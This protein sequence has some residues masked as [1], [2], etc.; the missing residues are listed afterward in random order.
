[1]IEDYEPCG[2]CGKSY[3]PSELAP[4]VH[5]KDRYICMECT[6]REGSYDW[7]IDRLARA[8]MV[9]LVQTIMSKK[10]AGRNV[11]GVMTDNQ[12]VSLTFEGGYLMDI[13]IQSHGKS[14]PYG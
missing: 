10:Y 4:S 8:V 7:V 13:S 9:D 11:V 14:L 1:M 5:D 2:R 3:E 12:R 6:K